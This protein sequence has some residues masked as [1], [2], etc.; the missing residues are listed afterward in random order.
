MAA[1]ANY[2]GGG[3]I[4][5]GIESKTAALI[6]IE[7]INAEKIVEQL[8]AVGRDALEPMVSIEHTIEIYTE[9]PLLFI[10]IKRLDIKTWL[11]KGMILGVNL[12]A[13]NDN[14]KGLKFGANLDSVGKQLLRSLASME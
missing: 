10:L 6:G 12:E 9:T 5:F 2:P 8:S 13:L 7:K 4:V 3:V 1:F 14:W 11:I